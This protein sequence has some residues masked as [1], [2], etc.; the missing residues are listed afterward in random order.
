MIVQKVLISILRIGGNFRRIDPLMRIEGR[1]GLEEAADSAGD[2][3]RSGGA[4][5]VAAVCD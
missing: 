3:V 5:V 2:G 4:S 1:R